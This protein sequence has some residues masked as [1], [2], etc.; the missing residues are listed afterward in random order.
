MQILHSNTNSKQTLGDIELLQ[1]YSQN[2]FQRKMIIIMRSWYGASLIKI[3]PIYLFISRWEQ[4]LS[5]Y[6]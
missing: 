2:I 4:V 3:V 6:C 1:D 5:S